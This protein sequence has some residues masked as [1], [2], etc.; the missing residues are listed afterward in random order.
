MFGFSES[1]EGSGG[2]SLAKI[3]GFRVKVAHG[4][5][6]EHHCF[7]LSFLY[8]IINI[9]SSQCLVI[10]SRNSL[11]SNIKGVYWKEGSDDIMKKKTVRLLK[12]CTIVKELFYFAFSK[13]HGS[14]SP[15]FT[16]IEWEYVCSISSLQTSFVLFAHSLHLR[17]LNWVLNLT[18]H[19]ITLRDFSL[20]IAKCNITN[21][22]LTSSE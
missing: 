9:Y 12:N 20:Y 21:K 10:R 18:Y 6:L 2:S 16:G 22:I 15:P 8:F 13:S 14:L 19:C 11:S 17:N 4:A 5:T 1:R 7:S 3:W